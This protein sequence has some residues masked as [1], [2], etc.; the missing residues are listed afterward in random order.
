LNKVNDLKGK[1][2]SEFVTKFFEEFLFKRDRRN[3][4]S[5][6]RLILPHLDRERGSYGLKEITLGKLVADA[7]GLP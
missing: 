6:L 2:K 1:K 5:Y 3:A 4:F 7:F